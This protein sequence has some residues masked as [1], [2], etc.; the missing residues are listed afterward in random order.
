[1]VCYRELEAADNEHIP[2]S[3]VMY[4]KKSLSNTSALD[5]RFGGVL[6]LLVL[7]LSAAWRCLRTATRRCI[8]NPILISLTIVPRKGCDRLRPLSS[9]SLCALGNPSD[10]EERR[11]RAP[12]ISR[13]RA[14][15]FGNLQVGL[16]LL[17]GFKT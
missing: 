14:V 4:S 3:V 9:M 13:L 6:L 12:W 10:P 1:M 7:S 11:Q 5:W 17:S 2:R 15:R 8:D 16:G